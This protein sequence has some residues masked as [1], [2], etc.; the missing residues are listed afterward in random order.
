MGLQHTFQST[1]SCLVKHFFQ[2]YEK[3][4]ACASVQG[5]LLQCCMP[6]PYSGLL[7]SHNWGADF[8]LLDL[9]YIL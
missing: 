3:P 4:Y 9:K 5:A 7:Q 8:V 1:Q 2:S 6:Q